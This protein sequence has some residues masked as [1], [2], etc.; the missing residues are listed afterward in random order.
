MCISILCIY[1]HIYAIYTYIYNTHT[2]IYIYIYI[3]ICTLIKLIQNNQIV[4]YSAY[5][6]LYSAFTDLFA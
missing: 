6:I 3:Y 5:S 1:I 4:N 2:Y